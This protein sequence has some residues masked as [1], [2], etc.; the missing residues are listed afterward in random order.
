M[1]VN[2]SP[3]DLIPEEFDS[4]EEVAA[5]WDTHD[6]TDYPDAFETVQVEAVDL[7]SRRFE[8]E[9]EAD[10]MQVLSEQAKQQGIAV[11]QLVNS[12]LRANLSNAA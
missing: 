1:S 9:V 4:Y 12:L 2:Q 5:F 3:V 7:K 8:V 10:L 6:T 11:S